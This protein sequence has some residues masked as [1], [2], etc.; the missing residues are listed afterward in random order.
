[1]FGN[2]VSAHLLPGQDLGHTTKCQYPDR[3]GSSDGT[4][5][6]M[7]LLLHPFLRALPDCNPRLVLVYRRRSILMTGGSPS[8]F[9]PV[10]AV[11]LVMG[12]HGKNVPT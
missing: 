9:H 7:S 11:I 8:S 6:F 4:W 5:L 2:V 10:G 1:M 3:A 12:R